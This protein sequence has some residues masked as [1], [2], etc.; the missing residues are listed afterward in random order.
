ML[1]VILNLGFWEE[2]VPEQSAGGSCSEGWVVHIIGPG[3]VLLLSFIPHRPT[4]PGSLASYLPSGGDPWEAP[5]ETGVGGGGQQKPGLSPQL[6]R[7][8]VL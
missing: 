5:L 6:C 1:P 3:I 8:F 2:V 7:L 4:L